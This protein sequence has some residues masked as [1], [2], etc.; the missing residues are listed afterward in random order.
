[1]QQSSP[2]NAPTATNTSSPRSGSRLAW[3][4]ALPAVFIV[5]IMLSGQ[6]FV[7]VPGHA[8]RPVGAGATGSSPVA[9]P[10]TPPP[11]SEYRLG[12]VAPYTGPI[13]TLAL[14]SG[15]GL[16]A[17]GGALHGPRGLAPAVHPSTGGSTP[18]N[19]VV[20][21]E[22]DPTSI[23]EV[24]GSNQTLL[25]ASASSA[26][27]NN[28]ST[29]LPNGDPLTPSVYFFKYG[30]GSVYRSTDGGT[31]WTTTWVP[32]NASWAGKGSFYSGE[33]GTGVSQLSASGTGGAGGAKVFGVES[34]SEAC[35][36][37]FEIE[38]TGGIGNCT[39]SANI[40]G[41]E[42][43]ALTES[44]NGGQSWSAARPLAYADPIPYDYHIPAV[45][46]CAATSGLLQY[47]NYTID[48]HVTYSS[49]SGV[50]VVTWVN[51][52]YTWGPWICVNVGGTP[53]L[54]AY[55][56]LTSTTWMT[57]STNGG[58]SF[59][60][61]GPVNANAILPFSYPFLNQVLSYTDT[62][63]GPAPTYPIYRIWNDIPNGSFPSGIVQSFPFEFSNSS[64]NGT[65]WSTATDIGN[66]K[67]YPVLSAAPGSF[68]N[69]TA[70]D[71]VV[72]N[73]SG[74][75]YKG[76]LYLFWNDNTT[77]GAGFPSVAFSRSTDGGQ[78]WSDP[79]YISPNVGSTNTRYFEPSASVAPNGEIWVAYY[80]ES[81][82]TS[83]NGA[84]LLTGSYNTYGTYSANGGTTWSPQ[85][86]ISDTSS[87][88]ESSGSAAATGGIGNGPT[89][90]GTTDG[91]YV[92]W[93][94]CRGSSC[95]GVA[96]LPTPSAYV[97]S[98]HTAGLSSSTPGVNETL[99][100]FGT[101]TTYALPTT[102]VLESGA[103]VRVSVPPWVPDNPTTIYAFQ[104]F[105]GFA[106]SSAN[107]ATLT[108]PGSGNLS[109]NFLPEPA[110]WITGT[111]GPYAPGL[112]LTAN[113]NPIPVS[114]FNAT[115]DSFNATI[116]AGFAYTVIASRFGYTTFSESVPTQ[117]GRA[118]QVPIWL[119]REDG[120]LSGKLTPANATLLVN[121]SA[122]AVN[123]QS[124][125][126]NDS[127][128]W[129]QYWVNASETGYT[130]FSQYVTV[131]PL[132][133]SPISPTLSGG[134]ITGVISPLTGSVKVNGV[135]VGLLSGN[136]N[137]SE[138]GGTYTLSATAPGYSSFSW[139]ILVTPGHSSSKNIALTNAGWIVGT[140]GP[141][142]ALHSALVYVAGKQIALSPT[143]VFN[144]TEGAGSHVVAVSATGYNTSSF[145]ESVTPGN[146]TYANVTLGVTSPTQNCSASNT[147]SNKG[148]GN[149][150]SSN[151]NLLLYAGIGI[152]VL[153]AVIALALLLTRRRRPPTSDEG[154][155]PSEPAP[156]DESVGETGSPPS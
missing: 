19:W 128:S 22:T 98:L 23:V 144:A 63:I 134:W 146:V 108:Y 94:D 148:G 51:D 145:S 39:S 137:V 139:T 82:S 57:I 67:V 107:P 80:G 44:S 35:L 77:T 150:T 154:A 105:S 48:P 20:A 65:S 131:S 58:V 97:T 70:P 106:S 72:D 16:P 90:A 50:V 38:F 8:V 29:G 21:N 71:L 119:P 123:A 46:A 40:S 125:A 62:A 93:L 156:Y 86:Q 60:T 138:P 32:D 95:P 76:D 103:S 6:P 89:L 53:E 27:L 1:M 109:A 78:T 88:I 110:G 36:Q 31:S 37:D 26:D 111:V 64:N 114:P 92:A 124:G 135:A 18:S 153:I 54:E 147:C 52:S 34:F 55:V 28:G 3:G 69:W 59:S 115:A 42:G 56:N 121:G 151:S 14:P 7:A 66:V 152:V 41:P 4:A 149:T 47:G 84:G 73:W 136:F 104:N 24:G 87:S 113:G 17:L 101:A 100:L 85:F 91:T 141:S 132:H 99:D 13:G 45:G 61:P 155:P 127:L 112:I 133:T 122:V 15:L 83:N 2:H 81:L 116:A 33:V 49:G 143:G 68:A 12:L 11:G 120:W 75:A 130:S 96:I 9:S 118:T 102:T 5:F 79:V 142:A 140:V 117:S 30:F 10:A 129:G 126:F 74:S 25:L 43:I